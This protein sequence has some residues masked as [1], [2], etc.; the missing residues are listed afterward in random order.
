MK[1][2]LKT[3]FVAL[4][5]L[6]CV[7]SQGQNVKTYDTITELVALKPVEAASDT[8]GG[9][10]STVVVRGYTAV[11]D[12]GG[13]FFYWAPASEATADAFNTFAATGIATGRWL[14]MAFPISP[15]TGAN[16]YVG[17]A[18]LASGEATVANTAV[19][20]TSFIFLSGT[21]T[22][23]LLKVGTVTPGTSFV[24]NSSDTSSD[25]TVNWLIVEPAP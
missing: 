10:T 8:T 14:R 12:G 22:N 9:L 18:T 24:I 6:S 17:T 25:R 1:T 15:K 5:A 16:K 21:S 4:V 23:D 13:G 20:G 3:L 19:K 7:C 11:G 2:F